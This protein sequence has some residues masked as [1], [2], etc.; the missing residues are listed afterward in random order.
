[1]GN[2]SK[3]LQRRLATN[4]RNLPTKAAKERLGEPLPGDVKDV[5]MLIKEGLDPTHA[6]YAYIQQLT[7]YFAEGVSLLPEMKAY[8]DVVAAAEDEYMPLGPPMSPLTGSFFTTWAFFDL[9]I[10]GTT[11]TLGTCQIE[12]NNLIWMNGEQLGALRKLN[13]SRMGIY[14]HVGLD[15]EL[16]RLQELITGHEF[17]CR[18][19]SGYRGR[20]G[21]LWYVRL[22]PPLPDLANNHIVFTTPYILMSPKD[23]WVQFLHRSLSK[24][25]DDDQQVG[26]RRLLKDGPSPNYWNEFVFLA[27]HHHQAEAIFLTG[28]PDLRAT[29]PHAQ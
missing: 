4:I 8:Y 15:G 21:E 29:L 28:I 27:Y 17:I 20:P 22:L 5:E 26:L 13:E 24:Y 9:R 19:G 7:S 1:M 2:I 23:D 14:E 12:A 6:V 10:G 18:S 11:D 16:V 25:P 3:R